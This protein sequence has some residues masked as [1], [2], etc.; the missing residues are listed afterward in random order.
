ME[1]S[2]SAVGVLRELDPAPHVPGLPP[3]GHESSTLKATTP[4]SDLLLRK[5][6]A[7]LQGH[8]LLP[9]IQ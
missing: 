3:G 4:S 5:P 1:G 9:Y 6:E 2:A 7:H 8:V